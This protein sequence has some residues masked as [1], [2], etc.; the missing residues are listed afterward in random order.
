LGLYTSQLHH[1]HQ[2]HHN[3][4]AELLTE[5]EKLEKSEVTL[6]RAKQAEADMI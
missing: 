5:S 3:S 1:I 4:F 2:L 6:Q